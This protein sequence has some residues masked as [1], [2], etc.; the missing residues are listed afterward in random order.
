MEH[1]M[2]V[3][4]FGLLCLG[5]FV[6][7]VMGAGIAALVVFIKLVSGP[8]EPRPVRSASGAK[9]LIGAGALGFAGLM[10]LALLFVGYSSVHVPHSATVVHEMPAQGVTQ[11]A[12]DLEAQIRRDV[13]R[14]MQ[15]AIVPPPVPVPARPPGSEAVASVHPTSP[16]APVSA[17]ADIVV[18]QAPAVAPIPVEPPT[19][20]RTT[21]EPTSPAGPP[22]WIKSGAQTIGESQF[23]VISS[24][25][26]ATQAEAENDAGRQV[27]ALLR[28]DLRKYT[29]QTWVRPNEVIGLPES[30]GLAVRDTHVETF[31]RDFGSFFAPMYRVWYRVELSPAVREPALMRWRAALATSRMMTAGGGVLALMCVPLAVVAF[32][33]CNRWTHGKARTPL[34][35]GMTAA[36]LAAW[37]V[38]GVVFARLFVLWG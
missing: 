22:A 27:V 10:C 7:F 29:S 36:V 24:K 5:L 33:R 9:A 12:A 28:D 18:A 21:V 8:T 38:G 14:A 6:M 16:P 4:A 23:L 19:A 25:Q 31:S 26:Y 13:E 2:A 17:V 32:G 30:L 3:P 37:V 34:A 11:P 20:D 15:P 1:T 35:F